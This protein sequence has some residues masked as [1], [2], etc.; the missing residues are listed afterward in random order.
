MQLREQPRGQRVGLTDK[1][2]GV[3]GCPTARLSGYMPTNSNRAA[4]PGAETTLTGFAVGA[5]TGR[6]GKPAQ[7]GAG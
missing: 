7:A 3:P 6:H 2:A 4:N 5:R 1:L